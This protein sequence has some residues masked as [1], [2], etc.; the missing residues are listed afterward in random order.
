MCREASEACALHWT[1][2]PTEAAGDAAFFVATFPAPAPVE[3]CG[4]VKGDVAGQTDVPVRHGRK[5]RLQ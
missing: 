3:I 2:L 1:E 5:E 4:L